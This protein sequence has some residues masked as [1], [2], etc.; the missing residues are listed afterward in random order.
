MAD[1]RLSQLAEYLSAL[2]VDYIYIVD[3]ATTTSRRISRENFLSG[4]A[5]SDLTAGSI[6]QNFEGTPSEGSW[7]LHVDANTELQFE[8]YENSTWVSKGSFGESLTTDTLIL[9]DIGGNLQYL[10]SDFTPVVLLRPSTFGEGALLGCPEEATSIVSDEEVSFF[11]T[12]NSVEVTSPIRNDG[13]DT[14]VASTR[15]FDLIAAQFHFAVTGFSFYL[16]AAPPAN[17]RLRFRILSIPNNEPLFENVSLFSFLNEDG[18]L[19]LTNGENTFNFDSC[20]VIERGEQVRIEVTTNNDVTL[21]GEGVGV[22][23]LPRYKFTYFTNTK[24]LILNLPDFLE[25]QAL[26]SINEGTWIWQDNF[27]WVCNTTGIQTGS[28]IDNADLWGKLGSSAP[29]HFTPNIESFSIENQSTRVIPGTTIAAGPRIFDYMISHPEEVNGN[30]TITQDGTELLTT[31]DPEDFTVTAT[32]NQ[33]VLGSVGNQTVFVLSGI[34][35]QGARFSR[36]FII[37]AAINSTLMYFDIQTSGNAADFDYQATTA[38]HF[39][40]AAR[41]T[42]VIPTYTGARYLAIAQPNSAAPIQAIRIG[43]V[44]QIGG[45]TETINAIQINSINYD[46]WLS[47]QP[48]NGNALSGQRI[49]VVR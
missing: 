32:I 16:N 22:A 12:D 42:I 4:R 39:N 28:F 37:R 49:E 14:L 8:R 45:F 6:V 20:L 25:V 40:I 15:T 23:F 27:I 17:T 48:Q 11:E 30:L 21:L 31:I 19:V 36:S 46:V 10:K 33:V 9:Q 26:G 34:S 2:N 3:A 38:Q 18:G 41:N 1:Q 47:N 29:T 13:T 44:D 7:R 35:N 43:G 5:F 24:A